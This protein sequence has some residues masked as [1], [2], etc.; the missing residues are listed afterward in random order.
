M[1]AYHGVDGFRTF[2]HMRGIYQQGAPNLLGVTKPPFDRPLKRRL[3]D[4]LM[5]RW[6]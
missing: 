2:S 3:V 6:S 5:S 4:F 1:G